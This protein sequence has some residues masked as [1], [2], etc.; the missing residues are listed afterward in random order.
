MLS[1]VFFIYVILK[2]L[3]NKEKN[4]TVFFYYIII[5]IISISIKNMISLRIMTIK[6]CGLY[7]P[8]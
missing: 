8:S 4:V 2:S 6:V 7:R 1:Y 3:L 5:I